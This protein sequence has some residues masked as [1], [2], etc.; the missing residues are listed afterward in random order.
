LT[1]YHR[2][3][4]EIT[5]FTFISYW[6]DFDAIRQFAGKD[7]DNARFYPEEKELLLKGEKKVKH[8]K[9]KP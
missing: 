1:F 2:T 4:R 6:T 5:H 3:E 7:Y 9:V 8:R